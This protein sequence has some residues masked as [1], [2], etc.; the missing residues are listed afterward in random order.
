[1]VSLRLRDQRYASS[2]GAGTLSPDKPVPGVRPYLPLRIA[3]QE[4]TGICFGY[5]EHRLD[6]IAEELLYNRLLDKDELRL[7]NQSP[8]SSARCRSGG[9]FPNKPDR[10][11]AVRCSGCL[12]T[13]WRQYR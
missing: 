5:V 11:V 10:V 1:M 7:Q 3:H 9:S 4:Q 12:P 8:I 13:G 6:E 2:T